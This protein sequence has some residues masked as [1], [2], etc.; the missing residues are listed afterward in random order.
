M[1]QLKPFTIRMP[2]EWTELLTRFYPS[3]GYTRAIRKIIAKHLKMIL[4]RENQNEEIEAL[5]SDLDRE[6][7][8]D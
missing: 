5:L 8:H 1:S 2:K 6:L 7:N 3:L 4:E